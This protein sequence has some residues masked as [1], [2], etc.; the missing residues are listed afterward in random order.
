MGCKIIAATDVRGGVMNRNGLDVP[1]LV[2]HAR[3]TRSVAGFPGAEPID[4]PGILSIDCE[5]LVPA[6]LEN[7]ITKDNAA[8]VKA[9]VV[10]EGANG[11][12]THEADA[13]LDR[14]GVFVVPDILCNGGGV[15]VSY[16]EWVQDLQLF[17]WDEE[18]IALRLARTMTKAFEDVLRF[19]QERKINM[20]TAA[21]ALAIR[22][23]AQAT[24][25]RGI[26]P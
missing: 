23:V 26:Y 11:P 12:T 6:A 13:I 16:F 3:K 9:K 18:E 10:A 7:Q 19:S 17:F 25:I 24:M 4:N 15:T 14:M 1:A 8:Q 20:R 2:E 21:Q 5:V 22:R